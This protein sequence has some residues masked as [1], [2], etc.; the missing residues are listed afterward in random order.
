MVVGP[1]IV[2]AL[3]PVWV[4]PPDVAMAPVER[5]VDVSAPV[6]SAVEVMEPFTS[7][8]E[9]GVTVPTPMFPTALIT[10]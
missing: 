8:A 10:T 5:L 9:R 3:V 6:L 1:V 2:L 7:N 4:I